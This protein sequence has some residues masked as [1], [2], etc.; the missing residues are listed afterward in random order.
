MFNAIAEEQG[1]SG[2]EAIPAYLEKA[3]KQKEIDKKK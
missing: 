2:P 1:L 3:F